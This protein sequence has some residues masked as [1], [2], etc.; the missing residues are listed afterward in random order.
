MASKTATAASELKNPNNII[1]LDIWCLYVQINVN[2]SKFSTAI[3]NN[4]STITSC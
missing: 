4:I 2:L 3:L 1:L